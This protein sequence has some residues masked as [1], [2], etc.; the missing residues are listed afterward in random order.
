[1]SPNVVTVG[2]GAR[3]VAGL[4]PGE[5]K[6]TLRTLQQHGVVVAQLVTEV[7][8]TELAT[9]HDPMLPHAYVLAPPFR[10]TAADAVP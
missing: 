4:V 1:L 6:P 10:R 8:R 7:T 2:D 9:P 5:N 3:V